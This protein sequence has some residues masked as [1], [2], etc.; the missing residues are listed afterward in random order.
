MVVSVLCGGL[1]L[2]SHKTILHYLVS[3]GAE[4]VPV[5]SPGEDLHP[6]DQIVRMVGFVANSQVYGVGGRVG[7]RQACHCHVERI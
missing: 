5:S 1:C 2:S 6:A 3:R 7:Y 4:S